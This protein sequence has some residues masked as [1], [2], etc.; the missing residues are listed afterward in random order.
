M[1]TKISTPAIVVNFKTYKEVEGYRALSIARTCQEVSKSMGVCI[2]VC[3]PIVELSLIASSVN[4]PVLSQH[5]DPIDA[6]A[7]TGWVTPSS[8]KAAGAAGSL[9]NHSERKMIFSDIAKAISMCR[10]A[11]LQTIACADTA[12]AAG[13][14]AFFR[15]D[16]IAVEP[17]E[18]IGGDVSVTTAKPDIVTNAIAS[19]KRVNEKIPVFCGAGVKTG[20]DVKKAIELGADGVLLASGVVKSSDVRGSLENLIRYL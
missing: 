14:I 8:V 16:F 13:A 10:E 17:P 19:V 12:E 20:E 3:P 7:Q 15:P 11:G 6:G 18:L 5:V 4:I 9:L 2:P 1:P